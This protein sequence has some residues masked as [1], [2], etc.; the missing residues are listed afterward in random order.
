MFQATDKELRIVR[1]G[2]IPAR[3]TAT[4]FSDILRSIDFTK[5]DAKLSGYSSTDYCQLRALTVPLA[6]VTSMPASGDEVL[7]ALTLGPKCDIV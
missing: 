5:L 1:S 4:R 2:L 7:L 3:Y 6:N